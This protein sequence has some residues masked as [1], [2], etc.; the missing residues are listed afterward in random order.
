YHKSHGL[1]T[2]IL[3]LMNIYGPRRSA[4][5]YS[6]VMMKFA[7]AVECGRPLVVYGDGRQT[8]DFKYV[9]DVTEAI[10]LCLQRNES[11]GK[12]L[13]IGTGMATSVNELVNLFSAAGSK[14]PQ[15]VRSLARPGEI[16]ESYAN[17]SKAKEVLGYEPG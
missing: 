17:I 9:T 7:E 10:G 16:R 5:P 1:K 11:V 14:R 6:G 8:K 13:N 4:G 2:V 12:T 3:R 15:V